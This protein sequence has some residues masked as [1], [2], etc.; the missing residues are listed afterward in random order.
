MA[1]A[2][3]KHGSAY[4][5]K[6]THQPRDDNVREHVDMG[7]SPDNPGTLTTQDD[8][9]DT[10]EEED[11]DVEEQEE[12]EQDKEPI[13]PRDKMIKALKKEIRAMKKELSA[14]KHEIMLL[15]TEDDDR[16]TMFLSQV[17]KQLKDDLDAADALSRNGFNSVR[18]FDGMLK[19]RQKKMDARTATHN[20]AVA[21]LKT[22]E[23]ALQLNVKHLK[24][25]S[26]KLK[27]VPNK[28]EFH[29]GSVNNTYNYIFPG[30]N[31]SVANLVVP[32]GQPHVAFTP[33]ASGFGIT[34]PA[35]GPGRDQN[36]NNGDEM[37]GT[38][39]PRT[40]RTFPLSSIA[41]GRPRPPTLAGHRQILGQPVARKMQPPRFKTR[42]T[43]KKCRGCR[44][45]HD[46]QVEVYTNLIRTLPEF[47]HGSGAKDEGMLDEDGD[48]DLS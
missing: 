22:E 9:H 7:Q 35:S 11:D 10:E 46:D 34:S 20:A 26:L 15:R 12:E 8:D 32:P 40:L 38:I 27:N 43:Y 5:Q 23:Q 30:S 36:N 16:E 25:E 3:R 39:D 28:Q 19:R 37:L 41:I 29:A 45:V 18:S 4:T 17:A 48:E 14:A 21:T 33:P 6:P 31:A 47:E 1:S 42:C 44:L 2:W 13:D 24:V